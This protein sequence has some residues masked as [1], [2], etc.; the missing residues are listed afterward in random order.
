[1]SKPN[2]KPKPAIGAR[3]RRRINLAQRRAHLRQRHEPIRD[4]VGGAQFTER[5]AL[6]RL[7]EQVPQPRHEG[8]RPRLHARPAPAPDRRA[9]LPTANGL[10]EPLLKKELAHAK[11][12][13][14]E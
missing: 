12:D 7:D 10:E 13:F 5:H 14:N 6:D 2:P 3:L 9:L 4:R 11:P 8:A 1:M